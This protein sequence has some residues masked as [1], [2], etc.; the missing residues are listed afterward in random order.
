MPQ[1]MRELTQEVAASLQKKINIPLLRPISFTTP[2]PFSALS[3]STWA[4]LMALWAS[5][6]AVSNP[7]DL[8]ITCVSNSTSSYT[9]VWTMNCYFLKRCRATR[10]YRDVIIDG[11]W[12]TNNR[13]FEAPSMDFLKSCFKSS[14]SHNVLASDKLFQEWSACLYLINYRGTFL[15]TI[16]SNNINLVNTT[17]LKTI[18]NFGSVMPSSWSSKDSPASLVDVVHRFRCQ[19]NSIFRIKPLVSTL[20]ITHIISPEKLK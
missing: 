2:M 14:E 13:T 10:K 12:D 5:S 8:S 19:W 17:V 11:L 20:H 7:K 6:T 1:N 16:T 3:A 9:Q 18:D 4:A 15:S